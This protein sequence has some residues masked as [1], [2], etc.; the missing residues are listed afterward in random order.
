[1]GG[2]HRLATI[3]ALVV[4]LSACSNPNVVPDALM[5]VAV[6]NTTSIAVDIVVNDAAIGSVPANTRSTFGAADLPSL[7][8]HVVALTSSGRELVTLDVKSGDVYDRPGS[9]SGVG[10]RVDLSCGRLD[11]Y[12]GPPLMGPIPG[13]GVPGDCD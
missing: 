1:M 6:D 10:A 2:L 13:P 8:W 7:P 4:A 11:I 3:G 9:Q 5:E 12:S